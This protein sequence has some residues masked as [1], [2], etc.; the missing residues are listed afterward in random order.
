MCLKQGCGLGGGRSTHARWGRGLGE[1]SGLWTGGCS[2]SAGGVQPA[3]RPPSRTPAESFD[4]IRTHAPGWRAGRAGPGSQARWRAP[5]GSRSS[6]VLLLTP[7][8]TFCL[9]YPS[10]LLPGVW[11]TR[12]NPR[13]ALALAPGLVAMQCREL[14]AAATQGRNDMGLLSPGHLQV[15][16]CVVKSCNYGW[17]AGGKTS[18]IRGKS[19]AIVPGL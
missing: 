17:W 4:H 6:P 19:L 10:A 11:R 14:L 3:L 13:C 16:G 8:Q 5:L 15:A 9:T 7:P 12:V 18:F 1:P 2:G